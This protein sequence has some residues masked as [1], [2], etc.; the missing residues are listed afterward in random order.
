MLSWGRLPCWKSC[1]GLGPRVETL[2]PVTAPIVAVKGQG[3]LPLRQRLPSAFGSLH[4][5]ASLS[6]SP[7]LAKDSL[8]SS[9][10]RTLCHGNAMHAELPVV[11][12]IPQQGRK[13]TRRA[14]P[15]RPSQS[16][17]HPL[18]A[19]AILEDFPSGQYQEQGTCL[20]ADANA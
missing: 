12:L 19:L 9:C 2:C 7:W 4:S 5:E 3:A 1:C 6:A 13:L 15:I 18:L 14:T 11:D 20:A 8:F 16:L 10:T 17:Q